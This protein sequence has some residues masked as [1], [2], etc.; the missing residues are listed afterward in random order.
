MWSSTAYRLR[1][2]IQ[3]P[4]LRIVGFLEF[5]I[6]RPAV[7]A[8]EV[9]TGVEGVGVQRLVAVGLG[10]PILDQPVRL[11]RRTAWTTRHHRP[12]PDVDVGAVGPQ[13]IQRPLPRGA[14]ARRWPGAERAQP[15][16]F[17]GYRVQEPGEEIRGARQW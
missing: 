12:E 10:H 8:V 15:Q 3:K 16:R 9:L 6:S 7:E 5:G 2:E 13:R 11:P 14:L 4:A 1:V 17:D